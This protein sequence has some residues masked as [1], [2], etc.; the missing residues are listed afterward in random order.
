MEEDFRYKVQHIGDIFTSNIKNFG[1][2]FVHNIRNLGSYIKEFPR[3]IVLTYNIDELKNEKDKILKWIGRRLAAIRNKGL[4]QDVFSDE[5]MIK[6]F[7]RLD[8]IQER[9]DA[10]IKERK[11]RAHPK[12]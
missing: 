12:S 8:I 4:E 5:E 1:D 10:H 3:D 6:L 11:E 9:I 7:Q 2:I